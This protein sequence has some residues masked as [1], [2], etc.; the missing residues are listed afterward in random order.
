MNLQILLTSLEFHISKERHATG[1][2][3]EPT[4]DGWSHR[5]PMLEGMSRV[6]RSWWLRGSSHSL[7][8]ERD[9]GDTTVTVVV[10]CLCDAEVH[11]QW[12]SVSSSRASR[13][14]SRSWDTN[15]RFTRRVKLISELSRRLL[16]RPDYESRD[17]SPIGQRIHPFECGSRL[18]CENSVYS[19]F[20]LYNDVILLN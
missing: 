14:A 15:W 4:V 16:C 10:K 8:S 20:P 19:S 7:T 2:D 13:R 11:Q 12:S 17:W 6:N 18:E 3:Q 5:V 1:H 9:T